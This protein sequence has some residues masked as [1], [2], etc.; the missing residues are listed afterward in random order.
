MKYFRAWNTTKS[1]VK[2]QN[3][4]LFV[5]NSKQGKRLVLGFV[6]AGSITGVI[7]INAGMG[8][9]TINPIG[10]VR[11][12]SS[13]AD[14]EKLISFVDSNVESYADYVQD[15]IKDYESF[16]K[17]EFFANDQQKKIF[18]DLA[19]EQKKLF[20]ELNLTHLR[21][22]KNLPESIILLNASASNLLYLNDEEGKVWLK[23]LTTMKSKAET[24]Y[25]NTHFKVN[26]KYPINLMFVAKE[27]P[28]M[29]GVE[30]DIQ[31]KNDII[32]KIGKN[33]MYL[34]FSKNIFN[35]ALKI[36]GKDKKTTDI[37]INMGKK[38][39]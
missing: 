33:R 12:L 4:V 22:W 39:N 17:D 36:W 8:S 9:I 19:K 15:I 25:R 29:F 31:D 6:K 38:K 11:V 20:S 16:A 5:E 7:T 32:N 28:Y 27:S 18:E 23:I 13:I 30:E 24:K 21:N 34:P 3:Y 35:E 1:S 10:N 2:S 26:Y 14:F 37:D